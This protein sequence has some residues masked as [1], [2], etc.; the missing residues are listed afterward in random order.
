[1]ISK[2]KVNIFYV[3]LK[4][5][6]FYA[7]II[8]GG[9]NMTRTVYSEENLKVLLFYVIIPLIAIFIIFFI[10]VKIYEYHNKNKNT[11][12][13]N[14]VINY[15]SNVIGIIF[16]SIL[17]SVSIGFSLAFTENI[18]NLN[19]IDENEFLYY[20]FMVFPLF[21]LIFLI[22]YICKFIINIR[23]K[24]KLEYEKGEGNL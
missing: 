13:T 24:E 11:N 5:I 23:K 10:G 6:F 1:M 9:V 3:Q 2:K 20:F 19:A 12:R 14:F 22:Y 17:L 7:I 8:I 16:T 18:R 15:W 4:R 21:P